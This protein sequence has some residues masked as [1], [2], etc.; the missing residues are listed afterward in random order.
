MTGLV[1]S[2]QAA[3]R[4]RDIRMAF[5]ATLPERL[6]ALARSVEDREELQR[7][8]HSLIGAAGTFGLTDLSEAARTLDRAMRSDLPANVVDLLA[9]VLRHGD[10]ALTSRALEE[11]AAEA[12]FNMADEAVVHL[13]EDDADQA[14][15]L[16]T[17]LR[18]YGF[19]VTA[20]T[21]PADFH[22]AVLSDRPDALLVDIMCG[23]WLTAGPETVAVLTMEGV[24]APTLFLSAR[25]D[26]DARLQ[27]V[28]AGGA[29]YLV[30]PID[31]AGLAER[32]D[33]VIGR[34]MAK[35]YRVLI[36]DDDKDVSA[37]Y[38]MAMAVAGMETRVVHDPAMAI[39]IIHG[40]SPDLVVLDN[41]MPGCSGMELAA[42]LRQHEGM[43][44]LPILFLTADEELRDKRRALQLGAEDLLLKPVS[45]AQ[46]VAHV[47]ARVR[48]ARQLQAMMARDSLTGALNHAM[49]QD[50]LAVEVARAQR[51][52]KPLAFA[53][54]DI[55]A[56]KRV[57][58]THGH[59]AGDRVLKGLARLLRQRLRRTDIVGRYG[60]EEFA[61]V[62]PG[63]RAEDAVLILDEM[64]RAFS[65][66]AFRGTS[67]QP[68]R[69]TFSAG[70]A[71]LSPDRD[72]A[73]LNLAAD[74]ALY[75]AKRSG[76]DRVHLAG[77]L[78][79]G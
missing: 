77:S 35:P 44:A 11:E 14:R 22:A 23:S 12:L 18:P 3:A 15:D 34:D 37:E 7:N 71:A 47:R 38:A 53:M 9:D 42:V 55:D 40:F 67:D 69:V 16:V 32:L 21:D 75:Y 76:R 56:F 28:R 41:R 78:T 60:G 26:F 20:F 19:K 46:L 65:S 24:T 4:H 33:A 79:H 5:L 51:E 61:V 54:I 63:T 48:R 72:V 62:L 50:H 2:A 66:I 30:K 10:K 17:Q 8:A 45:L 39:D 73:G 52:G 6:A 58:D 68:F 25:N 1:L 13:L 36:V 31:A 29:G 49:V 74:S 57:N 64:R 59:G 27:A 43:L 70:V